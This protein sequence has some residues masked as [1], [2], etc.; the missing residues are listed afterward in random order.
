MAEG[1]A[2]LLGG[3]SRFEGKLTFD[4]PLRIDGVYRGA[5]HSDSVLIIGEGADVEGQIAV[6]TVIVRG[7]S[8]KG[9]VVAKDA[10]EVYAPARVVGDLH[11]PSVFLDKGV[12]F[13]GNCRMDAVTDEDVAALL[14]EA[15]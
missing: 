9:R 5:I 11:S 2:T 12:A 8:L 4:S 15:P 13:Q 14:A 7:G 3:G 10:I 1:I 6:A